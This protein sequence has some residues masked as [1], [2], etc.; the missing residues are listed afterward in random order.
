MTKRG[1]DAVLTT[2]DNNEKNLKNTP[3]PL[4]YVRQRCRATST[5]F[6]YWLCWL[7]GGLTNNWF[8]GEGVAL[9]AISGEQS[10][11]TRAGAGKYYGLRG[12]RSRHM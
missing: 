3:T 2:Y 8:V 9:K 6:Q 11:V 4:T 10:G 5:G 7:G 12:R 1:D